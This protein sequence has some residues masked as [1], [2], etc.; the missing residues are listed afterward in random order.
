MGGTSTA[1][2]DESGTATNGAN[3]DQTSV[4]SMLGCLLGSTNCN[5]AQQT[6]QTA[7]RNTRQTSNQHTNH[8]TNQGANQASNLGV[9][10]EAA[11]DASDEY[12][13]RT[14]FV[15]NSVPFEFR[16]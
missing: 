13:M 14:F 7:N 6:G 12:A 16:H 9:P 4:S 3:T 2:K 5:N 1:T 15:G 10:Y 8:A 11:M